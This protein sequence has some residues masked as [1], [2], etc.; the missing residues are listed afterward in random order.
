VWDRDRWRMSTPKCEDVN[1][2][3]RDTGITFASP[4]S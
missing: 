3:A 2:M 1:A 4:Y